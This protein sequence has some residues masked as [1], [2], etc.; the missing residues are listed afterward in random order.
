MANQSTIIGLI[1][2]SMSDSVDANLKKAS[3]MIAEAVSKGAKIVVLPELFLYPYFCQTPKD[4]SFFALAETIP[5]T[6]TAA[7]SAIAKHHGIVLVGGSIYEKSDGKRFNT[8]CVFGPDGGM[9][10]TYRKSHIPHDPGFYEQDYFAPGDTGFRVHTTPFGKIAVLICY[11]QWFPEA[12]RIAT[13]QGAQLIVYPTAIGL[14]SDVP[15][16]DPMIPENWEQQWRAVQVGH[17][18]ANNVYVATVNRVGDE[19]TTHFWGGS[20]I[21]NPGATILTQGNDKEQVL[22]AECDFSYVK[23]MQDAWRFLEERRT[24]LYGKLTTQT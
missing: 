4:E 23:K 15:P 13:L 10:G 8:S 11:D 18:A 3:D 17:A 9:I 24:D 19:S 2:M 22:I 7:L 20:F 16:V 1:Q 5:G 21:A 14:P 6:S 12:A